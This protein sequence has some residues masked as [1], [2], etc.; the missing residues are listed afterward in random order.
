MDEIQYEQKQTAQFYDH[1]SLCRRCGECCGA[2][3]LDPC[4]KL[5][6]HMNGEYF[7]DD[8]ANRHSLQKTV[9]GRY[10]T[11]VDIRDVNRFGVYYKN[12]GYN[13]GR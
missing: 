11:C 2:G 4:A 7:C 12:C 3:G 1:E 5:K 13:L 8:Y 6:K 10:F 9:S